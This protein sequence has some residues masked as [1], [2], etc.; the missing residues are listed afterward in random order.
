MTPDVKEQF[1]SNILFVLSFL[2]QIR[3]L[4]NH[5]LL[6]EISGPGI[7]CMADEA[8]EKMFALD[9]TAKGQRLP[10]KSGLAVLKGGSN[11]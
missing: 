9:A 2:D 8:R 5:D 11:D 10:R 4:G 3:V 7:A 1:N 6:N